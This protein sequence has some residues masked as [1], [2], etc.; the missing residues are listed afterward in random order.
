MSPAWREM[1]FCDGFCCDEAHM[2]ATAHIDNLSHHPGSLSVVVKDILEGL[3]ATSCTPLMI[4]KNKR[5]K[6]SISLQTLLFVI[7]SKLDSIMSLSERFLLDI[8]F[9]K[10]NFGLVQLLEDEVCASHALICAHENYFLCS[11][12]PLFLAFQTS[13]LSSAK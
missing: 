7:S 3:P 1:S 11:S 2:A 10:I 9:R 6:I 13:S 5:E 8:S 4:R 12:S